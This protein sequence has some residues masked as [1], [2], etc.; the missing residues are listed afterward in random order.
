MISLDEVKSSSIRHG[1]L[2]FVATST[3]IDKADVMFTRLF[4]GRKIF[5]FVFVIGLAVFLMPAILQAQANSVVRGRVLDATTGEPMFGVAVVVRE[6]N[7]FAQTDFDGKYELQLPPGQ[8]RII[9]QMM[10]YRE[11]SQLVTVNPGQTVSLNMVMS[12]QT[13]A[14]V[15]VEDRALNNTQ[16]SLLALQ[17]KSGAVSDGVSEESIK[18][19]PDSSASDVVKRVTGISLIGGKYVFVRGL[20]ER[21]STTILNGTVLPSP[22]PDKRVVPLDLFPATLIKNIRVI[23]SFLPEYTAEFSGGLVLIE[24]KEYPDE[25]EFSIGLG[26][27]HNSQTTNNKFK[28]IARNYGNDYLGLGPNS[29]TGLGSKNWETP[30]LAAGLPEATPLATGGSYGGAVFLSLDAVRLGAAAFDSKWTPREFNAPYNKTFSLS[31]GDTLRFGGKKFGYVFGTYYKNRYDI[32]KEEE[33]RWDITSPVGLSWG[34]GSTFISDYRQ[35]KLA[36]VYK[37]SVL[38]GNNLNLAFQFTPEDQIYSKTFLSTNS[39]K[40]FRESVNRRNDADVYNFITETSRY[41]AREIFSETVGGDHGIRLFAGSKPH[42]L[43][44]H[45][46]YAAAIR[47]EP[48]LKNRLWRDADGNGGVFVADA[49][50][51]SRFVSTAEDIARTF[52]IDYELGFTQWDGFE[53]KL[54]FGY[55]NLQREK[56]F[57]SKTY[58]VSSGTSPDPSLQTWPIP[59]EV[60]FNPVRLFSNEIRF[61]ETVGDN[62]IYEAEQK[63]DALFIQT[64]MPVFSKVRFIGG[65]RHENS[66]QKSHTRK[67]TAYQYAGIDGSCVPED[68]EYFRPALME[69]NICPQ[70]PPN[71][72]VG[73]DRRLAELFPSVSL[74]WEV[75]PD[76]NLRAAYSETVTRPDLRELSEFS[77]RP[78]FGAD[79]IKGNANLNRSYIHNYD[80]RWEWYFTAEEYVGVGLF[81]KSISQP[82]ELVGIPNTGS[83]GNAYQLINAPQ[84]S[85]K[86]L[87]LD[88]RKDFLESFRFES[89]LY[90]IRSMVEVMEYTE[91]V[92]IAEGLASPYD[93]KAVLQPS[94]LERPL[95]GQ[96]E[97]VYNVGLSYFFDKSKKSNAGLFYNYFGDRIVFVG[98]SGLPDVYE[99]GIGTLDIVA[100]Y[101]PTEKLNVKASIKNITDPWYETFQK[102]L[103]GGYEVPY[104]RYRKG[105]DISLSASYKF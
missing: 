95:Q 71:W 28:A 16:A 103:I 58:F 77:F 15:V 27:E 101:A 70:N 54:K 55:E 25:F 69:A 4:Q 80:L 20:G 47:D 61:T 72:G 51:G 82:I 49:N 34:K 87:E 67:S 7:A 102:S 3:F 43:H 96:S 89:N 29:I 38:W 19:S 73:E 33:Y 45:Y 83:A 99:R 18:R 66:Y 79:S 36:T 41:I 60:A 44:W 9:F 14:E 6:A 22:E 39:E 105:R 75:T 26:L 42:R 84:A 46:N 30:G 52:H 98:G 35:L 74:V 88:F 1:S 50:D 104:T 93:P 5:R 100:S 32:Q 91:R 2:I 8:H 37:E 76:M 56:T 65:I 63:N 90:M 31:I 23:K 68:L 17:K 85:I 92:F 62:N 97:I 78:F 40:S 10:S 81:Q 12:V 13:A 53:S 57:R 11:K 86:G 24:T 94:L 48:E 21:Y 59:G 64:D